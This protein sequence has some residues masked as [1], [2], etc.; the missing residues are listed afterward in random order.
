MQITKS[1]K[2]LQ[3]RFVVKPGA[4][5]DESQI[6]TVQAMGAMLSSVVF[7]GAPLEVHLC[8]DHFQTLRVVPV[9]ADQM[10]GSPERSMA[11]CR[12]ACE[13]GLSV[14]SE[15]ILVRESRPQQRFQLRRA[16]DRHGEHL[17][18]LRGLDGRA[19]ERMLACGG[20]FRSVTDQEIVQ[21]VS[22]HRVRA[23]IKSASAS[24]TSG[25]GGTP[26]SRPNRSASLAGP[27]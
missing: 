14:A 1:G 10:T 17:K 13:E 12:T 19:L 27:R 11:S 9:A 7:G 3:F 5:K 8:D 22:P 20:L 21:R 23:S 24:A 16:G 26:M 2:M 4:D 6:P 25:R 15:R 18:G